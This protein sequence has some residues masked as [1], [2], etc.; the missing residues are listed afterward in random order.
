MA[1]QKLGQVSGGVYSQAPQYSQKSHMGSTPVKSIS[2]QE[3]KGL[4]TIQKVA[5]GVGV[6]AV[7]YGTAYGI[8]KYQGED[9]N[10]DIVKGFNATLTAFQGL[11]QS[12]QTYVGT[13][14][15]AKNPEVETPVTDAQ[16]PVTD[17]V[18]PNAAI[19][20][21]VLEEAAQEG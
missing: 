17:A 8:R 15:P 6:A 12:V 20:A 14:F 1:V 2:T 10:A 13:F 21:Q 16:T 7:A 3:S 9:V 11:S 4:S 18:D 19:V 5:I